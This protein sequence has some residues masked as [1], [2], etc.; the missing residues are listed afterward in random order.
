MRIALITE[1][2]LPVVGG[3]EWKVHYLA[4]EYLKHGHEAIVFTGRPSLSVGAVKMPVPHR[5]QIVRCGQPIPGIARL[6]IIDRL[7]KR[8]FLAEHRREPFDIVHCHHLGLATKIGVDIKHATNLPVAATTCGADVQKVPEINYGDRLDPA[9]DAV[10]TN[11]VRSIDVV[12]SISSAV[13]ADLE[14]MQPTARI[15]DIPNGV[16][17]G[18]FQTGPSRL[19]RERLGLGD[20]AVIVLSVGRNHIKKAYATGIAAF[21]KIAARFPQAHY[22]LVGRNTTELTSVVNEHGL[23]GRVYLVEQVPMSEMPHIYHSA[24]VFF[25]PSMVE[26]FAQVNAQALACGLPLVLT[27][28]PGNRDAGDH[29]GA[30]IAKTGDAESMAACLT[31]LLAD[32]DRRRRLGEQAHA[33]SRRYAWERIAE[34]YLAIFEGLVRSRA[35]RRQPFV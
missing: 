28:A 12:G 2:F 30:L 21:A 32:P 25:N 23:A 34:A 1:S 3:L 26:G 7:I 8:A 16:L 10:A 29:G 31:E 9:A 18:D 17:W 22:A 6:G 13:R 27:D 33:A 4:T 15:V 24:D 5:Y 19:L 14:G 11:N 20:D 35:P